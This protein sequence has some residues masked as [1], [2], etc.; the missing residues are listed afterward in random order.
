MPPKLTLFTGSGDIIKALEEAAELA[1][2]GKLEGVAI[3]GIGKD[4]DGALGYGCDFAWNDSM[5]Q[6]W[7]NMIAAIA[8][9]DHHLR[10]E[11]LTPE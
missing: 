3:C 4:A 9:A 2:Q 7:A 5:P 10:S 8:T 6:P 11:G 1:R